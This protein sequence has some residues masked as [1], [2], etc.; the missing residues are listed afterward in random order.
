ML[1]L[2]LGVG[3]GRYAVDVRRVTEVVPRVPLRPLPR[4]DSRIAGFLNHGGT[5]IP[6]VDL[7]VLLASGPSPLR[8]STRIILVQYSRPDGQQVSLGLIAERVTELR[9]AQPGVAAVPVDSGTG[10][11]Y[12]GPMMVLGD[13]MVQ[14]LLVDRILPEGWGEAHDR[15]PAV[16][17]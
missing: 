7:G 8:L 9:E 17:P 14:L 10:M 12:L 2:M 13:T 11:A 16:A 3:D 4:A 15:M 1:V 6:V 5:P